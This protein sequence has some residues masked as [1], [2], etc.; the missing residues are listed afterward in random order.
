MSTY[1]N[2]AKKGKGS[3]SNA[4]SSSIPVFTTRGGLQKLA[5]ENLMTMSIA[6]IQQ[7]SGKED[8]ID[9]IILTMIR[10]GTYLSIDSIETTNLRVRISIGDEVIK[11]QYIRNGFN[12]D[13]G[14][15]VTC[16]CYK[17]P[18][19]PVTICGIPA[20][21]SQ[22]DIETVFANYGKIHEMK[23]V[24]KTST[25]GYKYHNGNWV[26]YFEKFTNKLAKKLYIDTFKVSVVHSKIP[27]IFFEGINKTK[28]AD[29]TVEPDS[30]EE[31]T[32]TNHT[33]TASKNTE[34][35]KEKDTDVSSKTQ[36]VS[37]KNTEDNVSPQKTQKE[38]DVQLTTKSVE[39]V[40]SR[41][42]TTNNKRTTE[43]KTAM[44][45]GESDWNNWSIPKSRQKNSYKARK[46][47]I[48]QT[49]DPWNF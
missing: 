22:R 46:T 8:Y 1:A 37:S 18:C 28:A 31:D 42:T 10:Q 19:F 17:K 5:N 3:T 39:G 12:L 48:S 41:N 6:E 2:M 27:D 14:Q 29:G 21:I 32:M 30:Q 7:K 23:K 43:G 11:N 38:P 16:F 15:N 20:I 40:S 49:G 47:K 35:P 25:S 34:T 44:M 4:Q 9:T 13:N 26:I 33:F 24:M 36:K 45:E